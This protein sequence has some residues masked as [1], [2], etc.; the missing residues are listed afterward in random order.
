MQQKGAVWARRSRAKN[1]IRKNHQGE[2]F[3][4]LNAIVCCVALVFLSVK[5]DE[6]VHISSKTRGETETWLV[7]TLYSSIAIALLVVELVFHLFTS[8]LLLL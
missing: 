1:G 5:Q 8:H 6:L 4:F 2:C 3:L 7:A